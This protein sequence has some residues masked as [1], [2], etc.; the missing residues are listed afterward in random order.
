MKLWILIY[1]GNCFIYISKN[2]YIIHFK[3]KMKLYVNYIPKKLEVIQISFRKKKSV[4][5]CVCVY[6]YIYITPYI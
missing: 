4:C 1:F 2:N 6:V 5:T 3:V